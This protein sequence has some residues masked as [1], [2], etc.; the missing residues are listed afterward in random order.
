VPRC[1]NIVVYI[2]LTFVPLCIISL[3]FVTSLLTLGL[4][5]AYA[6]QTFIVMQIVAAEYARDSL[7]SEL[8]DWKPKRVSKGKR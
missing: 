1:Y 3:D 5:V 4:F 6:N 7:Q 2:L 8:E